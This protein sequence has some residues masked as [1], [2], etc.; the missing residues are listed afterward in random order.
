M[1][2]PID[3]RWWLGLP[4]G[5]QRFGGSVSELVGS[6]ERLTVRIDDNNAE[7]SQLRAVSEDLRSE[8][9]QTRKELQLLR[10]DIEQVRDKVPGL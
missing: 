10:D 6:F 5:A 9:R 4:G 1:S 3:P 7:T 2:T 8:L